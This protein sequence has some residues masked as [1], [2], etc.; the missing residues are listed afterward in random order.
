MTDSEIVAAA[1]AAY[2]DWITDIAELEPSWDELPEAH[3]L[4]LISA[5]R[6][7]AQRLIVET[8]YVGAEERETLARMMAAINARKKVENKDLARLMMMIQ[9]MN[10]IRAHDTE[11]MSELMVVISTLQLAVTVLLKENDT[12]PDKV[13]IAAGPRIDG[14]EASDG[15]TITDILDYSRAL[16]ASVDTGIATENMVVN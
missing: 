16:V 12:D 14:T 10:L 13:R 6:A 3:R 8:R 2:E 4:R 9:R 11:I 15:V 5:Q 7:A 1:K